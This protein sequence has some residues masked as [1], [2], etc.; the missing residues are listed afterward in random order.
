MAFTTG[1]SIRFMRIPESFLRWWEGMPAFKM[2]YSWAKC[3][4]GESDR[5]AVAPKWELKNVN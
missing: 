2:V 4:R 3:M 1:N 5:E